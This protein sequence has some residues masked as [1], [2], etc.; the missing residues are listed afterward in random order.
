M[1]AALLLVL[2]L[3]FPTAFAAQG[4]FSTADTL[5][6][7]HQW[8]LHNP[9][10]QA[11]DVIDAT[12]AWSGGAQLQLWGAFTCPASGPAGTAP[13]ECYTH[14]ATHDATGC[15][16]WGSSFV[17]ESPA[18]ISFVAPFRARHEIYVRVVGAATGFTSY[19]LDVAVNGAGRGVT[20]ASTTSTGPGWMSCNVGFEGP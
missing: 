3:A 5:A 2:L 16:G 17:D 19:S 10:V 9:L 14:Y 8:V 11:G 13:P 1:R 6:D 7:A 15:G 20:Q 4:H 18:T 12:L